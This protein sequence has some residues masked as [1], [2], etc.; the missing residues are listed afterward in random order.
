[1]NFSNVNEWTIPEGSVSKVTDSLGRVIWEKQQ[2]TPV[3]NDYFY[4]EDASGS[5]N[6]VYFKQYNHTTST[7]APYI[8]VYK[9]SDQENWSYVGQTGRNGISTTIPANGTL[10]FKAVTDG[11][12][13]AYYAGN[14][15]NYIQISRNCNVGGNIMSLLY[16]DNFSGTTLT[17]QN[18]YAFY[19]LFNQYTAT[20]SYNTTIIEADKL[21][22][23]SNVVSH[24]YQDM[25]SHCSVLTKA[26]ALPAT[27]LAGSCYYGM[28]YRCTNLNSIITYADDISANYCTTSWLQNV[29]PTGTFHNLGSAVYLTD[30]ASGIPTGW[31]EHTS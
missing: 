11:W 12:A 23:P 21:V 4:V 3:S 1:M 9:S 15:F 18:K 31:T 20:G 25:F 5:S 24:C 19:G 28:F 10:Y 16:G 13:D 6:T 2:P 26:P 7:D 8:Q 22:L 30:S 29:S 14:Y 27:T 17:A